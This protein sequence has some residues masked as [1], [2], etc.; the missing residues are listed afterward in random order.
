MI[1]TVITLFVPLLAGIATDPLWASSE[2]TDERIRQLNQMLIHDC[3][4]C[5]GLTLNGGLGPALT[6]AAMQG[7]PTETIRQTI[8]NGRK[9]TPMPPFGSML[10]GQEIDWLVD[11]IKDGI[12]RGD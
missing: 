9:G 2:L 3:G 11:A 5:H 12:T 1:R 7:K 4:S 10:T 8:V 6:P